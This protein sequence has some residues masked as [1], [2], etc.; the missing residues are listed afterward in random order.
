M[1][2]AFVG[3]LAAAIGVTAFI[4]LTDP[5]SQDQV[6]TELVADPAQNVADLE[7]DLVHRVS[8]PVSEPFAMS[9]P[10]ADQGSKKI[11]VALLL[12]TSG[13]MDGLIDQARSQ[14]WKMVN[15]LAAATKGHDNASI[16]IA[17]YQYGNDGALVNNGYVEQILPLTTDLDAVS[18]ALFA[19]TT[20]GGSEYAPWTIVEAATDMDWT[21]EEG[22]LKIAVIAGN[23]EFAQGRVTV[24]QAC[25]AAADKD[26]VVNPIFC[27]D[28]RQGIQLGWNEMDCTD[29]T[30]LNIDHNDKVAHVA[31]PYDR[32]VIALNQ[33]LNDTYVSFGAQG[34]AKA[35][36]QMAQDVNAERI[37]AANVRTRAFVKSKAAYNNAAWDLVDASEAE[38][39]VVADMPANQLPEE[40]R[41]MSKAERIAYINEKRTEREAIQQQLQEMETK[42][43]TYVAEQ[44]STGD[45]AQTLDNV[46]I[47]TIKEQATKNGFRFEK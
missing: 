38:P 14:L 29:G 25:R 10:A 21:E 44:Q 32:D 43:N 13:S 4:G 7:N 28:Y 23:E 34:R 11:Q 26:I 35:Q 12:D 17:L 36:N 33:R 41:N 19:L 20:N 8:Q 3:L 2:Y 16:E 42:V 39:S 1:K 24:P 45:A 5:F 47:G 6:I 30:Y 22:A 37:A 46:L 40:M 31:T 27:G 18:E 15:S 9:I